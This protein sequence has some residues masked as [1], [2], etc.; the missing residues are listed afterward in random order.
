MS[1]DRAT[2]PSEGRRA[3]LSV[4][5]WSHE[6]QRPGHP[7][8]AEPGQVFALDGRQVVD[9]NSFYCALGEAINGPGGYF[10]WNLDA[11]NDCLRGRWG[12]LSSV[13]PGM[14]AFRRREDTSGP[15]PQGGE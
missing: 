9:A 8:D 2:D 10:G 11:A 12:R 4:A 5:L 13:H 15:P 7:V 6:Y 3:W 1:P 14:T